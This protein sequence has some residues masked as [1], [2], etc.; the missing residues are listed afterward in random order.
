MSTLKISSKSMLKYW[1]M[2]RA[3]N[4]IEILKQFIVQNFFY[5]ISYL[6]SY[7]TKRNKK[8]RMP[9]WQMRG[10]CYKQPLRIKA[11]KHFEKHYSVK[12]YWIRTPY[13]DFLPLSIVKFTSFMAKYSTVF[14]R[15]HIVRP[16]PKNAL[17]II[18]SL[19][20]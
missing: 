12:A 8:N 15:S 1:M 18:T 2:K 11:Q 6:A 4:R 9:W 20:N 5:S 17:N 7:L 10:K 14:S 19:W 3:I 13:K 16:T